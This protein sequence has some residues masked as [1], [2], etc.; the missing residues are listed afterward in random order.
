LF[1][2][3]QD[4][5]IDAAQIDWTRDFDLVERD[6][7]WP[8]RMPAS[9]AK[10][11]AS[12]AADRIPGYIEIQH[13]PRNQEFIIVVKDSFASLVESW[14]RTA[15]IGFTHI[16]AVQGVPIGWRIYAADAALDD[17]AIR[18]RFPQLAFPKTTQII[19]RGGIQHS[20]RAFFPF[21]LPVAIVLGA[22]ESAHMNLNGRYLASASD[23]GFQL[24]LQDNGDLELQ[25]EVCDGA[26]TLRRRTLYVRSAE[27]RSELIALWV[28]RLGLQVADTA[29]ERI[30]GSQVVS[31]SLSP[32]VDWIDEL[33]PQSESPLT[34]ECL[35]PMFPVRVPQRA[36]EEFTYDLSKEL[37][38][39]WKTEVTSCTETTFASDLA[40]FP[41]GI[42]LSE[43][44]WHYK[45]AVTLSDQRHFSRAI[46]ELRSAL[47]NGNSL[48]TATAFALLQLALLRTGRPL[49]TDPPSDVPHCARLI[50]DQLSTLSVT[51]CHQSSQPSLA[52]SDISPI[53]EDS[54]FVCTQLSHCKGDTTNG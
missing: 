28:D 37:L 31:A 7:G 10:V 43:G 52:V 39:E 35:P 30:S 11:F 46:K 53:N 41:G 47:A 8:F 24:E 26:N 22:P 25:L 51:E 2:V 18:K 15:C 32:F 45:Q 3:E 42:A 19:L 34:T 50:L 49:I 23:Q 17:V 20:D 13:L 54:D 9:H 44:A 21:A 6:R 14:G 12:G 48:I 36:S 16:R 4:A 29:V 33:L 27:A 5:E 1:S 40:Q 38:R